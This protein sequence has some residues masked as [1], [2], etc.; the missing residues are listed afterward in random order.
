MLILWC[1]IGTIQ[2][3]PLRN[4]GAGFRGPAG[5]GTG[6]AGPA[7]WVAAGG[8][9][10]GPQALLPRF[11]P[12]ASFLSLRPERRP[13]LRDRQNVLAVGVAREARGVEGA[14]VEDPVQNLFAAFA[15]LVSQ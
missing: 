1:K 9:H 5:Q 10:P 6:M 15:V 14:P 11:S 2:P 8:V 4:Q 13:S 7:R 3:L 12:A